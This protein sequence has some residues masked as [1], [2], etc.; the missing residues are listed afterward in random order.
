[1]DI[2]NILNYF[3]FSIKILKENML[4]KL[5]LLTA[6]ILC[7]T[8]HASYAQSY[9]KEVKKLISRADNYYEVDEFHNA[10]PLYI[11]AEKL[12]PKDP[13]ISYRVAECYFELGHELKALPYL[14]ASEKGNLK[15]PELLFML[16]SANHKAHK[17]DK[18]ITYLRNY[19][20]HVNP[21]DK[22]RLEE[23]DLLINNCSN[24]KE[25]VKNP[26]SKV[27]IKNLG[28]GINSPYNDFSPVVSADETILIFTSRRENTTG[29]KK[30]DSNE[31]FEDIYMSVKSDTVWTTAV[32]M[33]TT[34]NSTSHDASVGLSPDGQE[35]FIYRATPA[36][37]GDL[38]V[39]TLTGTVWSEPKPLGS[40]INTSAWE[41]S[42]STTADENIIF[43]TSN[44]KGGY[45]GRDIYMS[46]KLAN[47]EFGPAVNLGP[48]INTKFDE[49]CPFIHA[50]GKTLYFSSKGHKSMGGFDIFLCTIDLETGQITSEIENIGYPINT[51][52]DDV[53]FVWSADNKRAYFASEREGGYGL[54]DIYMLEREDADAD[55]AVLKGKVISCDGATPVA[56]TIIV[57]DLDTQQ[58]VGIYNSNA[59]SGRYTVILPAG[60]NYGVT[61]EAQG[62]LFY[63]KNIDIPKLDHYVEYKD[64]IC[65]SKLKKGSTIVLRNVF[66]DVDKATLRKESEAELERLFKILTL[67]PSLKIEIGGHTD[68]DGSDLHNLKL[69]EA[70]A[71]TVYDYLV[72]K[73]ISK[74][75]LRWK[76]FGESQPQVPNDTPENKQLNRRTEIKILEE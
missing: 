66:F 46:R 13:M 29:G 47:G 9:P 55:L 70:R 44:R 41:P 11:E 23:V 2:S 21:K 45:G 69:S 62:Y 19:K 54:K 14:D 38:Y 8:L 51:A 22:A 36:N 25:M 68:S 3:N 72:A 74:E 59:S 67:N 30:D 32:N 10:L 7:L 73:G 65:L 34:I 64:E 56:A 35:L 75:M 48:K 1:L 37:G 42:A 18:A 31:Y 6:T 71:K 49:D 16:G 15:E 24:G 17:F 60:K 63:S 12:V 57:T 27:V 76:G 52:D 39:S 53:F 33:G 61:V 5:V 28:P 58:P 20:T 40:T 4:K 50:D 26:K 43:F